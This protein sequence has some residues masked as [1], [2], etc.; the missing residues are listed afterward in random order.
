MISLIESTDG[1]TLCLSSTAVPQKSPPMTSPKTSS[2]YPDPS[3]PP[4]GSE[5]AVVNGVNGIP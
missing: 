1:Y 2:D 3:T 5:R 4:N